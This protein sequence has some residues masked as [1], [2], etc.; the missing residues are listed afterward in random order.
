MKYLV[1]VPRKRMLGVGR[2][3]VSDVKS[4]DDEAS[5][6]AFVAEQEAAGKHPGRPVPFRISL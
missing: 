4:F 5:A 6:L 1:T 2:P 3:A